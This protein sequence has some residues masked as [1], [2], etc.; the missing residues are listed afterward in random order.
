MVN[1]G[2]ATGVLAD[3][4]FFDDALFADFLPAAGEGLA[5][6]AFVITPSGARRGVMG[7]TIVGAI[8]MDVIALNSNIEDQSIDYDVYNSGV[9]YITVR[10]Q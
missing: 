5:R 4:S 10:V 7:D 2:A 3:S 1:G 9:S 6:A 8:V